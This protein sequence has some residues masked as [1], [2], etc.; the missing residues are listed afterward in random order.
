[1]DVPVGGLNGEILCGGRMTLIV[2]YSSSVRSICELG[3]VY[4]L[5]LFS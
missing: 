3:G 5:L 1:M 2:V 4:E